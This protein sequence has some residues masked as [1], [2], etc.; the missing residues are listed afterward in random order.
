MTGQ[1]GFDRK[2]Y[3]QPEELADRGILELSLKGHLAIG[4]TPPPEFLEKMRRSPDTPLSDLIDDET[5]K[6]LLKGMKR[7]LRLLAKNLKK[8]SFAAEILSRKIKEF[9]RALRLAEKRQCLP[10]GFEGLDIYR[11]IE[12]I[13]GKLDSKD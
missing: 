3:M 6:G 11:F 8:K 10:A 7:D 1:E 5:L 12:D 9:E 13:K 2:A 4:S